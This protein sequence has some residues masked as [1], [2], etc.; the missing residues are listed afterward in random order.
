MADNNKQ[1]CRRCVLD[2][3]VPEIEFDERGICNYC[4]LHDTLDKDFPN[5]ESGQ[6]KLRDIIEEV[7]FRG[8]GR[9]YDVVVGVSGGT[10]STYLIHLAKSYGLRSLA[11]HCDNGWNSEISVSNIKNCL[12]KLDVD[13]VTYVIDW[14]EIRDILLSFMKASLPWIDAPTDIAIMSTLYRTAAKEKIKYIFV[15]NN[16]RTEGRQPDEWTHCDGK[17][18][19]FIQKKFGKVKLNT[20]PNLTMLDL[21]YYGFFKKIKMVR[22]F[23]HI[24]YNKSDTKKFI[25][26]KYGW[27]DYG[28]HHHESIFTRFAIGYWLPKKFGIDK[29]KV[30]FSALVRSG[31]MSREEAL[32]KIKELPY[33]RKKMEEDVEYVLKKLDITREDFEK[34]MNAPNKKFTD[35]PSYYPLYLKLKGLAK[36]MFKYILPFKPMM[37]YELEKEREDSY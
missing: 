22:P 21:F 36:I 8:K 35:Y 28:E 16:F 1:I 5:D 37:T 20:F 14:E 26:E 6:K 18:I 24:P 2:E 12:E 3:T 4:R 31:E 7:K 27:K 29:R 13:L 25:T 10:D 33:D 30:T 11:V 9:K 34:M 19:K 32:Q 17:Q 23:Y 15:G